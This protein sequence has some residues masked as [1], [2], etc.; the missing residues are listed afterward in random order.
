MTGTLQSRRLAA[1]AMRPFAAADGGAVAGI[2]RCP[3]PGG[4]R[5]GGR[6][7]YDLWRGTVLGEVA[8]STAGIA[9]T[10]QSDMARLVGGIWIVPGSKLLFGAMV[11]TITTCFV[12][13]MQRPGKRIIETLEYKLEQLN[14]LSPGGTR[15][16]EG[17]RGYAHCARGTPERNPPS[18][19]L[20]GTAASA[21]STGTCSSMCPTIP[22]ARLPVRQ[23]YARIRVAA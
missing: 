22:C 8:L 16:A 6:H 7:H 2:C 5:R 3:L 21:G 14:D 18:G 20:M 17:N 4:A 10:P 9:D 1:H 19:M 23:P 11:V 13:P 15:P 12:R